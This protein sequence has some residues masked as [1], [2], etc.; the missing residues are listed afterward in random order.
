MPQYE[1]IVIAKAGR[2][3]PTIT[4]M[5]SLGNIVLRNGGNVRNINVLGDRILARALKDRFTQR[6]TVGRYVQFLVDCNADTLEELEK[7]AKG[8]TEA[9]RI[10]SYKVKDF[11]KEAEV[12]KRSAMFMSPIINQEERNVKFLNALKHFKEENDSEKEKWDYE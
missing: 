3:Q 8:N 4:M 9:L 1:A 10:R 7:V 2:S 5:K 11:Y 6:Y 12:F